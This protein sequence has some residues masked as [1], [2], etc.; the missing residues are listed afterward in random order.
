MGCYGWEMILAMGP[1]LW[2]KIEE[3]YPQGIG[4]THSEPQQFDVAVHSGRTPYWISVAHEYGYC[5]TIPIPTSQ[6]EP[7]LRAGIPL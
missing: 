1:C 6:V 3:R 7:W 2:A 4:M 5:T